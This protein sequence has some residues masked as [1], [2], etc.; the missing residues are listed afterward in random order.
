MI[1]RGTTETSPVGGEGDASPALGED[2][3][4][5]ALPDEVAPE[6]SALLTEDEMNSGKITVRGWTGE[7][8]EIPAD[9]A[10][11][12]VTIATP[13]SGG[14]PPT[15]GIN[16]GGADANTGAD[17]NAGAGGNSD[18]TVVVLTIGQLAGAAIPCT[19][20]GGQC[21]NT[22]WNTPATAL[23]IPPT[24]KI[25]RI[26]NNDNV[27]HRLHG[28]NQVF[29]HGE[30]LAPGESEDLNILNTSFGT[31]QLYEHGLGGVCI[32]LVFNLLWKHQPCKFRSQN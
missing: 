9:S 32:L 22:P 2:V 10:F 4:G 26:V 21:K 6:E 12:V 20:S 25:L 17:A 13:N 27:T 15:S 16:A 14:T 3:S 24:A 19:Q 1:W 7:Q 5:A 11:K 8:D 31:K 29:P 30:Q 18:P 28:N 23:V